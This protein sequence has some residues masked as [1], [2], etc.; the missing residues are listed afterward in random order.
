MRWGAGVLAH[1][2][3][4]V[5]LVL[6]ALLLLVLLLLSIARA[7]SVLD[8]VDW[9]IARDDPDGDDSAQQEPEEEE[10]DERSA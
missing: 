5:V 7:R 2:L 1:L 6:G 4:P 3:D 9:V 10:R 8:Q